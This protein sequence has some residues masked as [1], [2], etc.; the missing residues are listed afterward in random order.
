MKYFTYKYLNNN[1]QK[2]KLFK[3]NL[4]IGTSTFSILHDSITINNIFINNQFRR[5]GYGSF[6]LNHIEDLS[7]NHIEDLSINNF[8]IEKINL[9]AWQ[10]YGSTNVTDF[11]EKNNYTLNNVN[12]KQLYDDYDIIYELHNFEKKI[13]F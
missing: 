8:K 1:I 3:N 6:I 5:N 9:L 4:K 13:K 10:P 2:I 11:F 7:M 12:D